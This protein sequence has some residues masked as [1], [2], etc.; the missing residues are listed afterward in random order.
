M[1]RALPV[2]GG[3]PAVEQ[4]GFG[5]HISAGADAGDAAP[6]LAMPRTNASVV[7]QRAASAR[8]RRRPR[9]AS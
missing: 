6:R 5:Q 8:P 3:A 4:A 2:R 7:S 9:S 1:P